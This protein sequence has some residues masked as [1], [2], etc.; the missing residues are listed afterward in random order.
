[1]Y[2]LAATDT[3]YFGGCK[4]HLKPESVPVQETGIPLIR[5]PKSTPQSLSEAGII[6]LE[7][8]QTVTTPDWIL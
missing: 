3:F 8:N 1:M 5:W 6:W 4:F 2:I 7:C